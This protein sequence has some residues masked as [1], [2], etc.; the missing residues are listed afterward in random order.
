M[1][2]TIRKALAAAAFASVAGLGAAL[3]D[4]DLTGPEALIALGLG[5]TAGA[6]VYQIPNA[7]P[8]EP[9]LDLGHGG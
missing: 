7:V 1:L 8:I 3:A 4:G 5:L 6:A 2:S 9:P